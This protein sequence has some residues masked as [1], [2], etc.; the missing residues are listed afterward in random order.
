MS[1]VRIWF[2]EMAC[3]LFWSHASSCLDLP[4]EFKMRSLERLALHCLKPIVTGLHLKIFKGSPEFWTGM[5]WHG[6]ALSPARSI[7]GSSELGSGFASADSS[8]RPNGLCFSACHGGNQQ[9]RDI[10]N[11]RLHDSATDS[12]ME[13][14]GKRAINSA[15]MCNLFGFRNNS[16]NVRT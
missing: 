14:S 1:S 12:C 3:C 16:S 10:T 7:T 2:A 6:L 5:D 13:L 8:L 4:A 11:S 15:P 9:S